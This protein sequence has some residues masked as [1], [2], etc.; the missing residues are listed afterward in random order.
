MELCF[1]GDRWTPACRWEVVSEF[2]ILLCLRAQLL[3]Y[4]LNIFI[5]THKFLCFYPSDSLPHP[6]WGWDEEAAVWGW[7]AHQCHDTSIS[8]LGPVQVYLKPSICWFGSPL[9]QA[10]SFSLGVYNFSSEDRQWHVPPS[11]A[12]SLVSCGEATEIYRKT[13]EQVSQ[14]L[15]PSVSGFMVHKAAWRQ[16]FYGDPSIETLD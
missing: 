9:D 7:A 8:I 1:P 11:P 3:L 15:C 12:A 13:K 2:L 16:K 10:L 14:F 4:L 6:T 5:S